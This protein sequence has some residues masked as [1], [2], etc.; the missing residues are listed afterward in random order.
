[1][2]SETITVM[3]T[4][5]VASTEALARLGDERFGAVQEA[6]LGL[7]R[8]AAGAHGGREVKSLGDGDH[9]RATALYTD[10]LAFEEEVGALTLARRTRQALAHVS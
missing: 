6:H 3:F 5:A 7:L 8:S 9:D 4:D 2:S 10:A 1:M